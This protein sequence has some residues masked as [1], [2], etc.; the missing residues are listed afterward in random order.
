MCGIVAKHGVCAQLEDEHHLA[1]HYYLFLQHLVAFASAAPCNGLD[2]LCDLRIDQVTFA[3]SHNARSGFDSILYYGGGGAAGSDQYISHNWSHQSNAYIASSW[4]SNWFTTSCDGITRHAKSKCTSTK[5]FMDLSAFG[6]AGLCT[7]EMADTCTIFLGQAQEECL[8][9]RINSGGR[10]VNFLLVDW[11]KYYY[12]EEHV[13]NKAKFMNEKNIQ[14]YL[15]RNIFLPE[16][17]GCSYH[18]GWFYHY[19]W[20]YCPKYG[21]CWVNTYC[22]KDHGICKRSELSCYGSCGY[23]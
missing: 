1:T 8:N 5:D 18:A 19:C 21:W 15:N 6:T 12:K 9:K 7:W 13:V 2:D 3:S 4:G 17:Q 11:I 14:R 22:G 20:K 16:L 10:T 23:Y